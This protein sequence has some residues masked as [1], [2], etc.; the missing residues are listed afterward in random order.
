MR[1]GFVYTLKEAD[2]QVFRNA[3]VNGYDWPASPSTSSTTQAYY[4][5]FN[6]SDVYPSNGPSN[7]RHGHPLRCLSTTAVENVRSGVINNY[8]ESN[9][10]VLRVTS[11]YGFGW[12]TSPTDE[13]TFTSTYYLYFN[14]SGTAPSYGPSHRRQG[15]P[16]RCL[17]TTAVGDGRRIAKAH[18]DHGYAC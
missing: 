12:S 3:S 1:S 6:A 13:A 16:L 14:D 5:G 2:H 18:L 10:Q 9:R 15:F 11:F 17:S 7:R 8:N 4:L